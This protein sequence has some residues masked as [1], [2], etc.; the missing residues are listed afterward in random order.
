MRAERTKDGAPQ[1]RR[2]DGRATADAADPS[3]VPIDYYFHA[4]R[5]MV[6]VFPAGDPLARV[7]PRLVPV[8]IKSVVFIPVA[9][10]KD[11]MTGVEG[12]VADTSFANVAFCV[13]EEG[14][15]VPKSRRAAY[16]IVYDAARPMRSYLFAEEVFE[17]H[18][19]IPLGPAGGAPPRG[20]GARPTTLVGGVMGA[21]PPGD[22]GP[23]PSP[24]R[25][26]R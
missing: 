24:P 20:P 18:V 9:F 13:T 23:L 19:Y 7:A 26:P 5:G 14:Y 2:V 4:D 22:L 10:K 21:T 12:Y 11:F 8:A 25:G 3:V 16:G 15:P 17:H 1:W 6:R